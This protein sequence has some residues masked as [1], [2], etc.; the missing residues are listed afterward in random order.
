M[1]TLIAA[2]LFHAIA[3]YPGSNP[4]IVI[5]RTGL[6]TLALDHPLHVCCLS[7]LCTGPQRLDSTQQLVGESGFRRDVFLDL[8]DEPVGLERAADGREVAI[9]WCRRRRRCRTRSGRSSRIPSSRPRRAGCPDPP[10]PSPAVRH[11]DDVLGGHLVDGLA[12]LLLQD[13]GRPGPFVSRVVRMDRRRTGR[14]GRPASR[15]RRLSMSASSCSTISSGANMP[16]RSIHLPRPD[17][18]SP[19]AGRPA[20]PARSGN[21]CPPA[22]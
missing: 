22:A 19:A 11:L 9:A 10:P 6:V 13:V 20:V 15:P 8:R 16:A 5:R 14:S 3:L 12:Q 17:L 1:I 4:G 21:A 18:E 7:L 2:P